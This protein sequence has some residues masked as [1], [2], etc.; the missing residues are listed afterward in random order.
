MADAKATALETEI[1]TLREEVKSLKVLM[2]PEQPNA[3]Q[4]KIS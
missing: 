3:N 2:S 4:L 1:A